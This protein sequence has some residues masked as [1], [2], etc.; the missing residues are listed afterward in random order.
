MN[1]LRTPLFRL[2]AAIVGLVVAPLALQAQQ[3]ITATAGQVGVSYSYQITSSA[4]PPLTYGATGLP[5][6]LLVNASTGLITGTPTTAG[7]FTGNISVTSGG[8]T[9]NAAINI[10]IAASAAASAI[11]SATT[12]TGTVGVPFA[13]TATGSNTPTNF[14]IVGLPAGLAADPTTGAISGSPTAV[15]TYAITLSANNAAGTG[16]PVTLTLTVAAPAAAPVISS[17]TS[18][19][20][21]VGAAFTYT[22]VATNSPTAYAAAGLPLGLSVD[23]TSGAITGSP[24]VAGSYA[25]TLTATGAGGTSA[26]VT[27]SLTVGALAP[28]TSAASA[29]GSLGAAFSYAVTAA[30][31]TPAVTSFN[32]SGLPAGLTADTTSGALAGTPTT[33]GTYAVSLS[34][35]NATGTGPVSVLTLTIG[36]RPAVTS[37]ATATGTAGTPFTYSITADNGPITAYAATGLPGG[38]TVNAGT[39]VISGTPTAA[40]VFP[41][42]LTAANAFGTGT[43]TTLTVTIAAAPVFGG[44]GGGGGGGFA[45]TAPAVT[46]QPADQTVSEGAT[47][48]F[49]VVASGTATLTYQWRKDGVAVAGAT[50]ATLTLAG[51]K[52]DDAGAYSVLVGNAFGSIASA[53][54]QL[55][56]TVVTTPPTITTQPISRTLPP[57]NPASFTVVATGTAPLGYQWRKAGTA[58][59]GAT[60]ATFTIP[61]AQLADSGA[62][63][64]VVTNAAGSV[65]SAVATLL[66]EP[67]AVAPALTTQPVAQTAAIGG[68]VTF[69]VAATGTGPLSYQWKKDGVALAGA[70][71]ATFTVTNAQ[72][73][74]AGAYSVTVTNAAGS[75]TSNA[76][77]LTVPA[78]RLAN[79]SVRSGAGTGDQTLIVGLAIGGTGAKQVLVRGIGPGLTQFGLPGA[80]ADPQLR[81]FNSAGVQTHVNEDWGGGAALSAAFTAVGAF[82]LPVASKDAAL[83]VPLATGTYTAQV[84][85][86]SGTGV[87]LLEAYDSDAAVTS[88]RFVNISARTQVGTGD[89]RLVIGFVVTGTGPKTVLIRAVGPGLTPFGVGGVLADP[90]LRLF[91]AAGNVTDTNDDWAS[92]PALA[93]AHGNAFTQTGAFGLT[94]ASKD[95]ALLVTLQPGAYT[96]QVSGVNATTGVAL[97]EVYELP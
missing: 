73:A 79:V 72:G 37:L 70:T 66:V 96:A 28:I 9:N 3:T 8:S 30:A 34:A 54:A 58:I 38:L 91:N 11:T 21:A 56:V 25:V 63:S 75:V 90:Q 92:T 22:I 19:S 41:V 71:A 1:F 6:G 32:I 84:A 85:A 10:T 77:T 31:V 95:A 78:A 7:A 17:A 86:A 68:N 43:A 97:V 93:A 12:A 33:V 82:A 62:Y 16:A 5:G 50:A 83:L 55:T 61:A 45:G 51:A 14:N 20:V 57:G 47:A 4:V 65:T 81:L 74:D 2:L 94:V 15:G 49:T 46:A 53:P 36:I 48:T 69:S 88:A 23:P 27:L 44:G 80:L 40:G 26:P 60:A 13:Y 67:V 87:A 89:N 29:T 35:N 24:S 59:A 52:P 64:V 42:S 76:V 18:A 39:G